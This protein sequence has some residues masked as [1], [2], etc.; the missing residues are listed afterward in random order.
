MKTISRLAALAWCGA[1]LAS[2]GT[3]GAAVE[4][5]EVLRRVQ[6]LPPTHPRL[7]LP[8]GGEE[9]I[10]RRVASDPVWK[11]LQ[12]GLLAEADRQ[13]RSKPVERVLIG[14]RLLDK[15]RT[16]LSRVMHLGLAWRLT[17]ERKY[18]ERARAELLAVA[19]FT[20]W[21]P[22]HFLDVGEMTA[23]VGL[24]YDWFYAALDEPTRRTLREAIVVKGL[25]T[26]Q[27]ANAWT[28]ATNNW[29]QVCN[30]GITI[31]ALAVAESAPALVAEMIARAVN[32][33]P[34]SMH[35]FSPDGAYPE[36]PGYWGYGTTFNVL[37]IS[38]LQSTLGT[39]FGLTAQPGFLATTDYYLHVTGPSGYHF[40]YS[41]AGR[42]GH[43][44][45][46]AMFWFAAQR[47]EPYLL[48]SEWPKI[49]AVS[50]KKSGRGGRDRTD[51]MVMLWMSPTQEKPTA[52]QALSW[53]GGGVTP[54][55][56]HRSAWTAEASYVAIKGGT[57]S[58]SHAHMDIGAFVMD[59]DGVRWA[60]D[61]GMQDYNSLE[62][63]GINL[64]GKGQDADR[65][66]IFRLGTSAHNVLMVD[67]QQQ[68]F[69]GQ[70]PIVLAKPGRTVVDLGPVYQGQLARARRG[71]A[72][73]SDRSVLVQDEITAMSKPA[74]VRWAMVTRAEVTIDGAGRAR[75]TQDGKKLGFRVLEPAGVTVKVYPTD[76]PPAATDAR[77]PGTRMVGFEVVV[78]ADA[79]R[80]IV[81]QLVP[82]DEMGNVPVMRALGE[83]N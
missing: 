20:D 59:A 50:G 49:T 4:N 2:G 72:L 37:L 47:K 40:N 80:R 46:A 19:A 24:G 11:D 54:V 36:G 77:N 1:L 23:A 9:A 70:A 22:K 8:A 39:D 58:A 27:T 55:A 25:Q 21:N 42:G 33:V 5:A 38:A 76:P 10:R 56:F 30:G 16:A 64:W 53:S 29:N 14:R 79:A 41:D 45:A 34:I 18:L 28:K 17:G 60:D 35:E 65:W 69:G 71:V 51:P 43:G 15:S 57:P 75:L 63:N 48:W 6:E 7:F 32:T 73:Q 31:G 67:G 68:R 3:A 81:V 74:T 62:S 44:V 52:P 83:W 26:S 78:G 13:L 66:K 82:R 12:A 61:L